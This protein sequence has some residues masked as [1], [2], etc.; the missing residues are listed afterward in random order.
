MPPNRVV[1]D[2][3]PGVL[4]NHLRKLGRA[5]RWVHNGVP[6]HPGRLCVDLDEQHSHAAFLALTI[7]LSRREIVF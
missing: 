4:L 6:D 5:D 3:N 7:F 2:L 1:A